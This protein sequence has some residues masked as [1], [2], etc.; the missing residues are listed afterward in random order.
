MELQFQVQASAKFS[1]GIRDSSWFTHIL[2]HWV[3]SETMNSDY[4][5][6]TTL[7]GIS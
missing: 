6:V 2:E 1:F 4:V 3:K 5:I 7:T